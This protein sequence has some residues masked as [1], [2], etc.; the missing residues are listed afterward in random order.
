MNEYDYKLLKEAVEQLLKEL[1]IDDKALELM[2][3]GKSP[4][5]E[6]ESFDNIVQLSK[7]TSYK[8]LDGLHPIRRIQ[9]RYPG[10]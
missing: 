8:L 9:R 6:D 5:L 7:E 10:W 3:E 2:A 4:I 1:K